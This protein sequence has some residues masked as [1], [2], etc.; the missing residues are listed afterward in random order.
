MMKTPYRFAKLASVEFS[1][2]RLVDILVT[3]YELDD[4]KFVAGTNRIAASLGRLGKMGEPLKRMLEDPTKYASKALTT[5]VSALTKL[6]VATI[7]G[8]TAIGVHSIQ[9]AS[10]FERMGMTIGGALGSLEKGTEVMKALET[11]AMRSAFQLGDLAQA[12]TQMVAAGLNIRT[13]LPVAERFALVIGGTD[14]QGLEMTVRALTLAKGGAFGEAMETL[15]RAGVSAADFRAQ[16]ISVNSSGQ[17]QSTPQQFIDAI[18]KISEGRPKAMADAIQG[19]T[20]VRISNAGDVVETAFRSI[21]KSLMAEAV[22]MIDGFVKSI[23]QL[24]SAGY[25]Q[26]FGSKI[27]EFAGNMSSIITGSSDAAGAMDKFAASALAGYTVLS[28]AT[29]GFA[30]IIRG[31]VDMVRRLGIGGAMF[32]AYDKAYT[33]SMEMINAGKRLQKKPVNS[34]PDTTPLGSSDNTKTSTIPTVLDRIEHN[35]RVSAQAD[36]RR[37]AFGAANGDFGVSAVQMSARRKS[38]SGNHYQDLATLFQ[39]MVQVEAGRMLRDARAAAR[40]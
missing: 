34:L 9:L 2:S 6:S 39:E 30:M 40:F 5:T 3:R 36:M 37:L 29:E 25:F 10:D 7:A 17:V 32:E 21:G 19:S 33:A 12:A 15:R 16:G 22:P 35:T 13:L 26:V 8:S 18:I 38:R 27:A 28:G 14:P 24:T 1:V 31:F 11:Y 20:A 23:G 4:A